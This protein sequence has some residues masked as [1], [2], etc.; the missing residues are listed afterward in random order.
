V[1]DV[2]SKWG[3][4]VAER[5]FAQIPTYLLNLNRFLDKDHRLSPVE[6]LVLFQL[7]GSWWKKDESPFPAMSTLAIRCGVS[8][9]QVQR[10]VT[11][12]NELKLIEK[13]NRKN[14]GII[15]SNAYSMKPL[16]N[17][18]EEVAKAFP[19]DYPRRVTVE[20]RQ[21]FSGKLGLISAGKPLSADDHDEP[22]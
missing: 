18:L 15:A 2:V 12:L 9:R 7:V 6:M 10:A 17:F 22:D 1:S 5:G 3:R 16:V 20:D 19:N 13:I 4:A 11:K 21:K 14:K 8:S